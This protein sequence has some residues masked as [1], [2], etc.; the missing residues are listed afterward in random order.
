MAARP[1]VT[2]DEV[3]EYT[4]LPEVKKRKDAKLKMDIAR[5]EL[6]VINYC[7]CKFDDDEKFP[8][9][10]EQVKMAVILLAEAYGHNAVEITKGGLKGETYDDY[11]YTAERFIMDASGVDVKSLLDEFTVAQP[12]GAVT[13]RIRAV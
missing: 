9:I 6:W 1:W 13:L 4:E 2:P 5:A 12:Q 10:P 8:T 3:R 7:N 11:S